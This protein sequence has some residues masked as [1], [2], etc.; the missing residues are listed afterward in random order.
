MSPA[1]QQCQYVLAWLDRSSDQREAWEDGAPCA[2][3]SVVIRGGGTQPIT[4]TLH[5][6]DNQCVGQIALEFQGRIVTATIATYDDTAGDFVACHQS[7]VA[8]RPPPQQVTQPTTL[9]TLLAT[10]MGGTTP[11]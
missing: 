4:I 7:Q 3:L 2:G 10:L 6:R 1:E 11:S 9:G 5:G 8:F